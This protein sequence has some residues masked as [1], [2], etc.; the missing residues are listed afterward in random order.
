MSKN[1]K[2]LQKVCTFIIMLSVLLVGLPAGALGVV[3][4]E[5]TAGEGT[6][7]ST[8]EGPSSTNIVELSCALDHE[9]SI[10]EGCYK[11]WILTCENADHEH[12]PANGCY[13]LDKDSE[14]VE[15][16]YDLAQFVPNA[17]Y[18]LFV[19]DDRQRPAKLNG[20][21]FTPEEE[22]TLRASFLIKGVVEP[23]KQYTYALPPALIGQNG[24]SVVVVSGNEYA[25]FRVDNSNNRIEAT[26]TQDAVAAIERE[27]SVVCAVDFRQKLDESRFTQVDEG[28]ALRIP[29]KNGTWT[30]SATIEE[31]DL[32]TAQLLMCELEEADGHVHDETCYGQFWVICGK[33]HE[34]SLASGCYAS[35]H[36]YDEHGKPIRNVSIDFD[37]APIM[38][39]GE[40]FSMIAT[41]HGFDDVQV[42]L[43]W[44]YLDGNEWHDAAGESKQL[45]YTTT[46]SE[47]ALNTKWRI[48]VNVI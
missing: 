30:V 32:E 47:K 12:S 37:V 6:E 39:K 8:G 35:T 7:I 10:S 44:Q 40:S 5:H 34:H 3:A 17:D 9:H 45:I 25:T 28:I 46:A 15:H 26:F 23:G 31:P 48:L 22:Y 36:E 42:D 27:G 41:L 1:Q 2:K 20:W 16:N 4:Q 21:T 24:Q 29:H 19:L 13:R 18:G 38:K 33:D 43:Q 14:P 11:V